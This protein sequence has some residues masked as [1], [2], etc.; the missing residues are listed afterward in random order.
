[1]LK[2]ICCSAVGF[3]ALRLLLFLHLIRV[4]LECV[5]QVI[6]GCHLVIKRKL[7]ENQT[8]DLIVFSIPEIRRSYLLGVLLAPLKLSGSRK[9]FTK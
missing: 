8:G 6:S 1:M 7:S 9:T 2:V 5:Q 4:R 3:S